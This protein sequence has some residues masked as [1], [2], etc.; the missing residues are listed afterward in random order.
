[1]ASCTSF[2]GS[3]Q[4]DVKLHDPDLLWADASH[5]ALSSTADGKLF[6]GFLTHWLDLNAEVLSY[7]PETEDFEKPFDLGHVTGVKVGPGGEMSQG[8]IHTPFYENDKVIYF[9]TAFGVAGY[10]WHR[11]RKAYS[12]GCFVAY[13]QKSGK[14]KVVGRAPKLEGIL[15]LEPDFP[16]NCLYGISFPNGLLMRCD[17]GTGEVKILGQ[18]DDQY[19]KS[20]AMAD[21]IDVTRCLVVHPE[22]GVVYGSRKNGEIWH[23]DPAQGK[24]IE[25]GLNVKQGI[26]GQAD[27]KALASSQW[28]MALLSPS[29]D[30]IYATHQGT[31]SLFELDLKTKSITPLAR[32]CSDVDLNTMGNIR[33]SRLAFLLVDGK[34]HHLAHGPAVEVEGR[35]RKPKD[36]VYYVTHDLK[37]KKRVDHGPLMAPGDIR[38]CDSDTLAILPD[39]RLFSLASVELID[40]ARIEEMK[41]PNLKG[42]RLYQTISGGAYFDMQL[43]ELPA[44]RK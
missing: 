40:S 11:Q 19:R 20:K 8:K 32:I 35:E 41:S 42:K 23:Y 12:G 10:K 9:G 33:G 18:V 38:V 34:I 4:V 39:G 27:D 5:L 44:M 29:S 30:K 26:V 3:K 25:S 43:V 7:D 14:A 36:Q 13:D 31:C 1:M 21:S 6:M 28:R 22:S 24:I 15:T 2:T 37:S 17:I 16:R